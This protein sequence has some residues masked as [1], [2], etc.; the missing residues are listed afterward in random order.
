MIH[1]TIWSIT[2]VT[3]IDMNR[4]LPKGYNVDYQ[5]MQKRNVEY[6]GEFDHYDSC[7]DQY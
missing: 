7:F 6:F 1:F 2:R 5:Y 4:V 3:S